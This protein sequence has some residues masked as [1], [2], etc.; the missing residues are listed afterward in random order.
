MLGHR[1]DAVARSIVRVMLGDRTPAG[2]A[3]SE[4][5]ADYAGEYRGVGRAQRSRDPRAR[6][7]PCS[8]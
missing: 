3:F 6:M 4:K 8:R 5:A 7:I 1:P 2:I